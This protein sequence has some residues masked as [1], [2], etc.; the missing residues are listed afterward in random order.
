M[1]LAAGAGGDYHT[2]YWPQPS[3]L[4]SRKY[5]FESSFPTYHELR[6][7]P[8]GDMKLKVHQI[9]WHYSLD[10]TFSCSQCK[11]VWTVESTLMEIVQKINPGQPE[12]PEWIYNGAMIGVQ[13]GTERM[14]QILNDAQNA[15]VAVSGLWIQD[16][17]GKYKIKTQYYFCLFIVKIIF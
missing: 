2:T 4:S 11:M 10:S 13:G 17:S 12:L 8:K 5:H 3:F 7:K 15:G 9:Y 6:F 16:W 14:L 1:D